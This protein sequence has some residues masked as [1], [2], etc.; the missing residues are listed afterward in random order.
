MLKS[1]L[2]V[3]VARFTEA[4]GGQVWDL[5]CVRLGEDQPEEVKKDKD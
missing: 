2:N 4:L 5:H 3:F 1:N